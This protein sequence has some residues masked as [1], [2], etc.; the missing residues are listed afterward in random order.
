LAGYIYHMTTGTILLLAAITVSSFRDEGFIPEPMPSSL[1]NYQV[2][3]EQFTSM[4]EDW[5]PPNSG[6]VS[7]KEP[8]DVPGPSTEEEPGS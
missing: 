3:A 5:V 1:N 8:V 4:K 7:D 6:I 2:P